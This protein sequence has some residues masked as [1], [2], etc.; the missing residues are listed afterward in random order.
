MKFE[1]YVKQ[2][3][4]T[5][6]I[7]ERENGERWLASPSVYMLIPELTR[8]VTGVGISKMP[9]E[10]EKIINAV[11]NT[12]YANL[13][14]AVMPFPDGKIA[15]CLR[16]YETDRGEFSITISNDDWSL[17]D[18]SDVTEILYAYNMQEEEYEVKALLVKQYPTL[19]TEDYELV[20]IIFPAEIPEPA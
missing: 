20:G 16:I 4:S 7:Y 2:L 9:S 6:T 8:S 15:D 1:K 3:A 18:K 10:I 11:G 12:G 19:P 17:I 14:R 13:R 5:G